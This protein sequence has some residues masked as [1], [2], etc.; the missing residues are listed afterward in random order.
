MLFLISIKYI[1]EKKILLYMAINLFGSLFHIVALFYL[2]F[3]FLVNIRFPKL[4]MFCFFI[5]GNIIFLF[6][7]N[8]IKEILM[9]IA[10]L[11]DSRL[12]MLIEKY[13]LR[14]T[15]R[16]ISIGYL[17]RTFTFFL[18][19]FF[20]DK[21]IK[22]SSTNNIFVNC[23]LFYMFFYLCG[24]EMDIIVTRGGFLFLCSY[25]ILYPQIYEILSKKNKYIFLGLLLLYGIL[26]I[27]TDSTSPVQKYE[28]I[29][30]DHSTYYERESILMNYLGKRD[31]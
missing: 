28:N 5:V 19:L 23:Y 20:Y 27:C 18:I 31:I 12:T 10:R 9:F 16:G 3:Y 15:E 17:E 8:W 24:A 13:T 2:P 25:W 6:S 4:I 30:F 26:R 11:Y 1:K 22:K 14:A 29:L 7:I 21:L